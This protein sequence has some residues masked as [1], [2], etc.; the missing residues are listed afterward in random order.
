MNSK[1]NNPKVIKVNSAAEKKLWQT[2]GRLQNLLGRKVSL[3]ETIEFLFYVYE[4]REVSEE[5][6]RNYEKQK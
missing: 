5:E 1:P 4:K 2:A 3:C 6:M